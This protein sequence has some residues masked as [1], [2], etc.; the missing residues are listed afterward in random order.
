MLEPLEKRFA[1]FETKDDTWSRM[2]PFSSVSQDMVFGHEETSP[3]TVQMSL[4]VDGIAVWLTVI[5]IVRI[6]D[7]GKMTCVVTDKQVLLMMVFLHKSSPTAY[8][9]YDASK[10]D[11]TCKLS[12]LPARTKTAICPANKN[13]QDMI[14][15]ALFTAFHNKQTELKGTVKGYCLLHMDFRG[16]MVTSRLRGATDLSKSMAGQSGNTTDFTQD[17]PYFVLFESISERNID[18]T[19]YNYCDNSFKTKF[20]ES[21]EKARK[22]G[23]IACKGMAPH[24][25]PLLRKFD[26]FLKDHD[27]QYTPNIMFYMP[28]KKSL[29]FKVRRSDWP[30]FQADLLSLVT[31]LDDNMN[32]EGFVVSIKPSPQSEEEIHCKAKRFSLAHMPNSFAMQSTSWIGKQFAQRNITSFTKHDERIQQLWDCNL[33]GTLNWDQAH[34]SM[35]DRD[36]NHSTPNIKHEQLACIQTVGTEGKALRLTN[37][38]DVEAS[39]SAPQQRYFSASFA[40]MCML[41]NN[42]AIW[43]TQFP[44]LGT[45]HTNGQA[46]AAMP[47]RHN[48]VTLYKSALLNGLKEQ[49]GQQIAPKMREIK[50][51]D[52]SAAVN[53]NFILNNAQGMRQ[54]FGARNTNNSLGSTLRYTSALHLFFV[55]LLKGSFD[56]IARKLQKY[57]PTLSGFMRRMLLEIIMTRDRRR[58]SELLRDDIYG[59]TH[60]DYHPFR[61]VLT[62][63]AFM[64]DNAATVVR[65]MQQFHQCAGLSEAEL[66]KMLGQIYAMIADKQ[67]EQTTTQDMLLNLLGRDVVLPPTWLVFHMP[68]NLFAPLHQFYKDIDMPGVRS[69]TQLVRALNRFAS[70][71]NLSAYFPPGKQLEAKTRETF[72]YN[73]KTQVQS[74]VTNLGLLATQRMQ[75]AQAQMLKDVPANNPAGQRKRKRGQRKRKRKVGMNVYKLLLKNSMYTRRERCTHAVFYGRL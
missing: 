28:R 49:N 40:L 27:M 52:V 62:N 64:N 48:T 61:S 22:Q 19:Y 70:F 53:A 43:C 21:Y 65:I 59:T 63:V 10:P 32:C 47:S 51:S 29:C 11:A 1:R 7:D 13:M 73:L 68:D 8:D 15:R 30:K 18:P 6:D 33:N 24:C 3:A 14:E 12:P 55:F 4:K 31:W 72:I 60:E 16:E 9:A 41:L 17:C 69:R 37:F 56:D 36:Y 74:C 66:S 42:N 34:S 39:S 5:V 26:P 57:W 2:R 71:V 35:R 23:L 38:V 46:Y 20:A 44:M 45:L 67:K 58:S 50:N 75:V 54:Y 25:M